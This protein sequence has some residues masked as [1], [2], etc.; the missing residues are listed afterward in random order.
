M[1]VIRT[2][3]TMKLSCSSLVVSGQRSPSEA[4]PQDP[5][6]GGCILL[7]PRPLQPAS[8]SQPTN[9]GH[10]GEGEPPQTPPLPANINR[11]GPHFIV[12]HCSTNLGGI[13][14]RFC[15]ICKSS[16]S[17]AAYF[18]LV[19]GTA[20]DAPSSAISKGGHRYCYLQQLAHADIG[21]RRTRR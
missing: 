1:D 19:A 20:A 15:A 12:A 17:C 18:A 6:R 16:T 2:T 8:F 21:L 5:S 4:H 14:A 3:G 10:G 11:A 9:H 7:R 13:F